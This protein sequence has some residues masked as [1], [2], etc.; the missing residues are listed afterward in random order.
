MGLWP[1]GRE[2]QRDVGMCRHMHTCSKPDNLNTTG[3]NIPKQISGFSH[4]YL[5]KKY[6]ETSM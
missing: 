1:A 4:V 3:I 5:K 2:D 6:W